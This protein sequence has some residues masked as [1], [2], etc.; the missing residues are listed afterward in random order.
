[1]MAI[2]SAPPTWRDVFSTPEP[3]P[4]LSTGTDPI[5][6]EVVG[7]I[8]SAM[9]IPPT[10]SAGNRSHQVELSSSKENRRSETLT[11]SMP[12]LISQ[13]DPIRSESFPAIGATKMMQ[14]VIGRN[15]AP[16]ST[17]E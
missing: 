9:P 11:R 13:R 7:V 1:M 5:A 12:P 10:T 4:A 14:S 17:G 8:A 15:D 16:A 6:A 3:T 2:P